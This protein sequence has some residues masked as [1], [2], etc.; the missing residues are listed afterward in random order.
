MIDSCSPSKLDPGLAGTY[1]MPRL[2]MTST[3]KS[4]AG[5]STIR[6]DAPRG[7]GSVSARNC[8]PAGDGGVA[9]RGAGGSCAAATGAPR[10]TS[11]AAPTAAP[12]RKRR[13][14]TD[15]LLRATFGSFPDAAEPRRKRLRG[16]QFGTNDM[17]VHRLRCRRFGVS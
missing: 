13:R 6:D 4:E 7:G 10:V 17:P 16:L 14:A 8:A 2:L 9:G 11:A 5:F 12:C 15:D 3:M 1:S